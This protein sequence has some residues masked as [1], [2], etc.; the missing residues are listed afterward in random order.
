MIIYIL[1]KFARRKKVLWNHTYKW[2]LIDV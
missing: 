1:L 2:T